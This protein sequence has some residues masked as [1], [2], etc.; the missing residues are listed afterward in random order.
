ML[1]NHPYSAAQRSVKDAFIDAISPFSAYA[2]NKQIA[3]QIPG[4]MKLG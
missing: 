1:Q 4:F 2:E 3:G